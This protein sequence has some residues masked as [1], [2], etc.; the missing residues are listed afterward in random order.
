MQPSRTRGR[1]APAHSQGRACKTHDAGE[2]VCAGEKG[3]GER[4]EREGCRY[5]V[6][7]R[8]QWLLVA[9]TPREQAGMCCVFLVPPPPGENSAHFFHP[10]I[11]L[12]PATSVH[13]P[14]PSS[15]PCAPALCTAPPEVTKRWIFTRRDF[16]K[17]LFR[18]QAA[19]TAVM[20]NATWPKS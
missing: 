13:P 12:H 7:V 11:S 10:G 4:Q 14:L 6:E 9:G 18:Q 19:R 8:A 5:S 1:I 3:R 16:L 2:G 20:L 15:V 17:K